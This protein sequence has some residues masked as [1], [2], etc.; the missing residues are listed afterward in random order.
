MVAEGAPLAWEVGRRRHGSWERRP[1]VA[2]EVRKRLEASRHWHE[3]W[4]WRPEA[5]EEVGVSIEAL[6]PRQVDRG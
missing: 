6:E 2:Q 3:R 4:G 5:A 1:K